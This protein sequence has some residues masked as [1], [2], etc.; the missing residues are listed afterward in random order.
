MF[1]NFA[2]RYF[3]CRSH[4]ESFCENGGQ[5]SF[6]FCAAVCEAM[7]FFYLS[8][9]FGN[10][11]YEVSHVHKME[12]VVPWLNDALVFFTVSLQLCQQLK[13]KVMALEKELCFITEFWGNFRYPKN[14]M[15]YSVQLVHRLENKQWV[16]TLEPRSWLSLPSRQPSGVNVVW[17]MFA[18][19]DGREQVRV[20]VFSV[21]SWMLRN[22]S[23]WGR[24][25]GDLSSK[26]I[27]S[28]TKFSSSSAADLAATLANNSVL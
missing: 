13:D 6:V 14:L 22:A 26:L 27:S 11:R 9:E 20:F 25:C 17:Q 1:C 18:E 8:S 7:L 21:M 12:C 10:Q 16:S 15:R 23:V 2:R 5:L 4:S 19:L 28:R 3:K 24:R